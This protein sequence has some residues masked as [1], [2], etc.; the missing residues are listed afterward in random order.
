MPK[1]NKIQLIGQ[2]IKIVG[3][4]NKQLIGISGTVIDET[5]NMIVVKSG[6]SKK[7]L[8]KK[9]IVFKTTSNI[10]IDAKK[11]LG[12]SDERIKNIQ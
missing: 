11:M 7:Q 1:E 9:Q 2:E 8:I 3:S 4:E 12:R 5:R 6:N 10:I